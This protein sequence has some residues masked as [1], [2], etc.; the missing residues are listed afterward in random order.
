MQNPRSSHAYSVE[1]HT[2]AADVFAADVVSLQYGQVLDAVADLVLVKD[3]N[4]RI[5][6]ANKAF[7][8][9]YGMNVEQLRGIID[10]PFNADENT[11]QYLKDDA[12]VRTGKILDI[13]SENAT[14][15]NGDVRLFHTI[16][17]PIRDADGS[18]VFTVGVAREITETV[19]ADTEIHR[20]NNDLLQKIQELGQAN[21]SIQQVADHLESSNQ[22]L[23]ALTQVLKDAKDKA[24][25]ASALK[26]SFLANMSHEIR[27]PLNAIVGYMELL[28]ATP[29]KP[30]Q[31]EFA[32]VIHSSAEMLRGLISDILDYSKIEAG[33]FEL[34]QVEFDLFPLIEHSLETISLSAKEK[35]LKLEFSFAD[36]LPR[37]VQGDPAR[38]RQI[39]LNLLSNA[40]K[41]TNSGTVSLSVTRCP[42]ESPAVVLQFVIAD[43]GIG[44]AQDKLDTIMMPFT[45]ADAS[46]TR[47][48][49]GTGL[50]LCI[51]SS[52]VSLMHGKIGV[53][54]KEGRGSTFWFTVPLASRADAIASND[55][56]TTEAESAWPVPVIKTP[57]IL[58][59][60]DNRVNLKMTVL[61]LQGLGYET[62]SAL[63]GKEALQLMSCRQHS[64]ILMDC[65]MPEMD[66][67]D[68][69][70]LIR[71][72]D[73][74][75]HTHT[76]IIALTANATSDDKRLCMEAGMDD[77]ITKPVNQ[78][79]LKCA[80][81]RQLAVHNLRLSTNS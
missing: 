60:E 49:G 74:Q 61:L 59:V 37:T 48:F 35:H 26:S 72:L 78:N 64:L 71:E 41:F 31:R 22:Q 4:S 69:T 15:F 51:C 58:V 77:Y 44:I 5:V 23:S 34:E 57:R 80:I 42:T 32:E 63:N 38:I 27:T 21:S 79:E 45:Q 33:K 25:D 67:Y 54:S 24:L 7:C 18:I 39:L 65:Q 36:D 28:L 56:A 29:M 40:V 70:R 66:G 12:Y 6:Y 11:A 13:P 1:L 3:L 17:S 52:L 75:Q 81:E 9:F 14:K 43:T 20:L 19:R 73:A 2:V 30:Q 47:N 16:K 55:N 8:E 62:D 10:A 46:T 68:A 76:P 53:E 50:G